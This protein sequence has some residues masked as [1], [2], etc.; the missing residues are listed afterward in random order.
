MI[1]VF[2]EIVLI[3]FIKETKQF[4]IVLFNQWTTISKIVSASYSTSDLFFVISSY[5]MNLK[6][7]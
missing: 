6:K 4:A 7:S 3:S 1:F 5:T 2:S